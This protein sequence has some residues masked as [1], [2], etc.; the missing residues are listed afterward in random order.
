MI[1]I[2]TLV[3]ITALAGVLPISY[4]A[5]RFNRVRL[6][7]FAAL[8]WMCLSV[9]TGLAG[10]AAGAFSIPCL[11]TRSTVAFRSAFVRQVW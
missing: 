11:L 5:D 1:L 4:L 2:A 10:L 8:T 6:V 9:L 3:A 7:A